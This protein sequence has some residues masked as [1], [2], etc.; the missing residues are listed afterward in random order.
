MLIYLSF[1]NSI[2]QKILQI[3][4]YQIFL[5]SGLFYILHHHP[6]SKLPLPGRTRGLGGGGLVAKWCPTLGTP[7]T[8]PRQAP[9]SVRFS[10][11]EYCS[12]L[13]FPAPGGRTR[14]P[15]L[16]ADSLQ[17]ELPG[18]P[19]ATNLVS[20]WFTFTPSQFSSVAQLCPTLCDPVNHSTPGL[21]VHHQLR[22]FTQTHVHRVGDAIQPSHPLLSASPLAPNPSQHQSLF[23]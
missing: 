8:V 22:E 7:W 5:E 21:P 11:Q 9:V 6:K 18:R 16:Q 15:E 13:P 19:W 1:L 12:G 20:D 23:Q 3:F 10:R 2:Y 14:S 4:T 17:T